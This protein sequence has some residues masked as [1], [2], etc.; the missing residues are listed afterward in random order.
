[1]KAF[2]SMVA[3]VLSALLASACCW[4]PALLGASAT[5]AFAFTRVLSP[6]RP[7]LLMA[8]FLFLAIGFFLALKPSKECCLTEE[9]RAIFRHK[10]RKNLLILVVVSLFVLGI[11]VYPAL[12]G[13]GARGEHRTVESAGTWEYWVRIKG[14]DCE[15]CTVLL[16]ERLKEVPG[17]VSVEI[18]YEE[19]VA[20]VKVSSLS[21]RG[22]DI[23]A[24]IKESGFD[25]ELL[26]QPAFESRGGK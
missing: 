11:S 18:S 1:M 12:L 20:R 3:S 4:V 23:V 2:L 25:A 8:T 17:V 13:I 5:G 24:K 26:P 7:Y 9:G 21:V 6:W 16:S 14:M 19:G 10:Q 15:G 22:E